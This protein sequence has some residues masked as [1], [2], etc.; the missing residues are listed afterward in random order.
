MN[1][2]ISFAWGSSV[3]LL[4]VWWCSS[5]RQEAIREVAGKPIIGKED[6]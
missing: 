5:W 4:A 2:L 1:I 3:L 6:T